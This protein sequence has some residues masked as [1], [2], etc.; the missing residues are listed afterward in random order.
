CRTYTATPARVRCG[1]ATLRASSSNSTF[2]VKWLMRFRTLSA[3]P[4]DSI[5][6]YKRCCGNV[7]NTF[8]STGGKPTTAYGKHETSAVTTPIRGSCVG[9]RSIAF[10]NCKHG[11]ICTASQ[12][13]NA[14]PRESGFA[15]RSK[16]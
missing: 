6:T 3:K 11:D 16:F 12:L 10:S 9:S 5:A 1:S 14:N 4:N 13:E 2:T 15:K 8:A 7:P